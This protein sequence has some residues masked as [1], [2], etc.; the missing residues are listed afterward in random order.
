M[1]RRKVT[2]THWAVS[3]RLKRAVVTGFDCFDRNVLV[4]AEGC[5]DRSLI[6]KGDLVF[7]GRGEKTLK[8][9]DGGVEDHGALTTGLGVEVNLVGVN[10]V[11]L[12]A[13]DVGGRRG[14]Q[15]NRAEER[16]KLEG[17]GLPK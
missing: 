12:H 5:H 9:G 10:E 8:E 14:A 2:C 1:P 13:P 7:G 6:G 16:A 4:T 15:V 3:P 17:L 11:G